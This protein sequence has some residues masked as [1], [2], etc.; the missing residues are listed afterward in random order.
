M[1]L[2]YDYRKKMKENDKEVKPINKEKVKK[3]TR[4]KDK[5]IEGQLSFEDMGW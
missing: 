2:A 5:N 3:K 4:N 1:F